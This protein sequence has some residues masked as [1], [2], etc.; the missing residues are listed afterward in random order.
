MCDAR[1]DESPRRALP[2]FSHFLRAPVVAL[3]HREALVPGLIHNCRV[4]GA[5]VASDAL[6]TLPAD[7]LVVD[8][9]ED[10]VEVTGKSYTRV[11]TIHN[12]RALCYLPQDFGASLRIAPGTAVRPGRF[13]V[14]F[15]VGRLWRPLGERS[16]HLPETSRWAAPA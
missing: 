10:L 8:N 13:H 7:T 6:P 15:V 2:G 12:L 3:H 16:A 14:G 9:A 5:V 1:S 4:V 11:G